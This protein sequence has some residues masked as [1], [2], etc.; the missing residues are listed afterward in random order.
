MADPLLTYLTPV[1]TED[2]LEIATDR[3]HETLTEGQLHKVMDRGAAQTHAETLKWFEEKNAKRI[4]R[5]AAPIPYPKDVAG[6]QGEQPQES[7]QVTDPATENVANLIDHVELANLDIFGFVLFRT[8]Y[9]ADEKSWDAFEKGFYELLD[10]GIGAAPAEFNRIEDKVFMR[11]ISDDSLEIQPPEG[12]ARAYLVCM[13]AEEPSRD[14]DDDENDWGDK[15]EPGLT[16][17]MCLFA[18]EECIRS[19]LDKTATPFVKAIDVAFDA[20]QT[21]VK[22]AITSLVPALHAA[23]LVYSPSDV[24]SKVSDD[25][26]WK[27]VGSWDQEM[28]GRRILGK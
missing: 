13:E 17:S 10:E 28:E 22:I 25:G 7:Q 1:W 16:T 23:L 8:H 3:D 24:A 6:E 9:S 26:I 19:V 18:D 14:D 5:G 12:V 2:K 11:I 27:S 4:A 20:G 21:P 15:I